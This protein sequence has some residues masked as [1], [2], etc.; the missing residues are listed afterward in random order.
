MKSPLKI[1]ALAI[2]LLLLFLFLLPIIVV[3]F[4][5]SLVNSKIDMKKLFSLDKLFA[6]FKQKIWNQPKE[7]VF[8]DEASSV[9]VSFAKKSE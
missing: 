3:V 9:D 5:L 2:V 4:M 1:M 6:L 8:K 7:Q